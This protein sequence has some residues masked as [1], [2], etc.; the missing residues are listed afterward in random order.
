MTMTA[1]EKMDFSGL[2]ASPGKVTPNDVLHFRREVFGDGVISRQEAEAIFAINIADADRC[3]EWTE[4]FVEALTD[5]IVNQAEPRGYV[6]VD[7][8]EWLI[9]MV[10][11]DG[12]V[13][14]AT[15]LELLIN[16]LS[17]SRQSPERLV[18]F[19][20][21]E[22]GRAVLEGRGPLANGR[23]L[24]PGAIGEPEVELIRQVLFAYGGEEGISI[25]KTEA[26]FLFLMNDRTNTAKNHSSWREFFVK[27]IANYLMAAA[28]GHAPSRAE[29]LAR[30]EWLA[31]DGMDVTGSL[32]Q[33]FSSFGSIFSRGFLD[34]IF[35]DAHTQIEKAWGERNRRR[36][37]AE[38]EAG[39]ITGSEAEWLI[40]RLL[41]CGLVDE[42]ERSLL[43]H[44]H[45]ESP[46]IHQDL[47]PVLDKHVV[48]R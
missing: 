30:E 21:D 19:V 11:H 38:T 13:E 37:M 36:E 48:N 29:A 47:E 1:N 4:F 45:A 31:D 46:N 9:S 5:H 15:E 22:I 14:A 8:A 10:S 33:T 16:I 41:Q 17:A 25:S 43:A 6:T 7:N 40:E 26:E 28:T 12:H 18:R 35:D 32:S 42:N 2:L 39:R 24:T 34:G 27:A 23:E 20:L 3:K 44:L